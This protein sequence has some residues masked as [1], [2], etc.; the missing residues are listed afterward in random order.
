MLLKFLETLGVTFEI[1][2]DDSVQIGIPES[3][4]SYDE[5]RR[6]LESPVPGTVAGATFS[7]WLHR[8]VLCRAAAR[9]AV[10]VGGSLNGKQVRYEQPSYYGFI[11]HRLGRAHWEVYEQAD[12]RD[13]RAFFRGYATSE[14]KARRGEVKSGVEGLEA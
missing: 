6:A 12:K 11:A 5:M 7:N 1:D 9:R 13:G 8:E 4:V 3:G 10:F 2:W 14:K